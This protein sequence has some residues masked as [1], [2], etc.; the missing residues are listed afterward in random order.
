MEGL[1]LSPL[2]SC[3]IA[4]ETMA[5]WG[6]PVW[7][8]LCGGGVTMWGEKRLDTK[9]NERKTYFNL[10]VRFDR[11]LS[12]NLTRKGWANLAQECPALPSGW[13]S[14]CL[15]TSVWIHTHNEW[16]ACFFCSNKDFFKRP[17]IQR[18]LEKSG[19]CCYHGDSMAVTPETIFLTTFQTTQSVLTAV[20]T[21]HL[22]KLSLNYQLVIQWSIVM[23]NFGKLS[24]ISPLSHTHSG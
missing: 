4:G 16:N 7:W 23:H 1:M 3:L 20:H 9:L 19:V 22:Y 5:G 21:V 8:R 17:F 24:S 12:V 6:M 13:N 18:W 2:G 15:T 11:E 10:T 14:L